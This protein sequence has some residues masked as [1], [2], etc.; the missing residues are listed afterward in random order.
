MEVGVGGVMMIRSW[1]PID[2]RFSY[3]LVDARNTY[4]GRR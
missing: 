1:P 3:E 4:G 2:E